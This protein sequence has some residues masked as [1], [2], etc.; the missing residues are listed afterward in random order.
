MLNYL[1][2]DLNNEFMS[3]FKET[4]AEMFN[5]EVP[6]VQAPDEHSCQFCNFKAICGR[7]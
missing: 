6:F 2:G 1:D 3:R 4:V 5:P 7:E